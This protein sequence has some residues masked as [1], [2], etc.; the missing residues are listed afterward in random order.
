MLSLTI[1]LVDSLTS[2]SDGIGKR[3]RLTLLKFLVIA[4]A[5][6][7]TLTANVF[8]PKFSQH[9]NWV[10][11]VVIWRATRCFIY[12]NSL[13]WCFTSLRWIFYIIRNE[14]IVLEI[15]LQIN[16]WSIML[17]KVSALP[18]SKSSIHEPVN[19]CNFFMIPCGMVKQYFLMHKVVQIIHCTKDTTNVIWMHAK[20]KTAP[21]DLKYYLI[22]FS[23]STKN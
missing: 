23:S 1:H 20:K 6:D 17:N 15:R 4:I 16:L 13:F 9:S 5:I 10:G 22:F 19:L 8:S 11:C 14:F 12:L 21:L 18:Y 7:Y 3:C 2:C